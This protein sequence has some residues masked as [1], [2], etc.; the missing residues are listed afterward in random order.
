MIL[1]FAGKTVYRDFI[2]LNNI[3]DFGISGFLP[4]LFYVAG[5][6]LLLLMRP[7]KYPAVIIAIVTTASLLFEL[8][9]FGS[10]GHFDIKD[11]LASIAGGI[12]AFSAVK[13]IERSER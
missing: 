10:T 8:K 13:F 5:F 7:V 4:S 3:S 12:I 1:G 9:Q 6:S 11:S 2:R